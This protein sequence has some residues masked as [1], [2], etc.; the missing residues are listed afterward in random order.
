MSGTIHT[1]TIYMLAT[2]W[3]LHYH[4]AQAAHIVWVVAVIVGTTYMLHT[5]IPA[6][7]CQ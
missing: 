3:A 4:Q 5:L 7:M 1:L 2:K 6:A